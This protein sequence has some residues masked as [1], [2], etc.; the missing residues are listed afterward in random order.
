MFAYLYFTNFVSLHLRLGSRMRSGVMDVPKDGMSPVAHRWPFCPLSVHSSNR[1]SLLKGSSE[2]WALVKGLLSEDSLLP[3]ISFSVSRSISVLF[4]THPAA[5]SSPANSGSSIWLQQPFDTNSLGYT[6]LKQ[7]A[8]RHAPGLL[9]KSSKPKWQLPTFLVTR[10]Y[11][12]LFPS[13][14]THWPSHFAV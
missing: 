11:T 7:V 4:P 1:R 12:S 2:E 13:S 9:Q 8:G 3:W 5:N 10:P 6:R 14:S